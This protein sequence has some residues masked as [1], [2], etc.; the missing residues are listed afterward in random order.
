[1]FVLQSV[2]DNQSLLLSFALA[3]DLLNQRLGRAGD[4]QTNSPCS[5]FQLCITREFYTSSLFGTRRA[6]TR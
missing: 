4:R 1:M 3:I 6:I 2:L 5:R